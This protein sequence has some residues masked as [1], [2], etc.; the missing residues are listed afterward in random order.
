MEGQSGTEP[1][2]VGSALNPEDGVSTEL[3]CRHPAGAKE[4]WRAPWRGKPDVRGGRSA[5]GAMDKGDEGFTFKGI[6]F[7]K[8][9]ALKHLCAPSS[10]HQ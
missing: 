7:G 8:F 2:S 6:F 1:S 4:N 10:H 9:T 5:W 3:N